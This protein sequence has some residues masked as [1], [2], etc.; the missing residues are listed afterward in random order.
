MQR[1]QF[2]QRGVTINGQPVDPAAST[3]RAMPRTSAAGTDERSNPLVIVGIVFLAFVFLAW[4]EALLSGT[5]L[6]T[7]ISQTLLW[8]L[9]GIGLVVGLT[10]TVLT[11]LTMTDVSLIRRGLTLLVCPLL[12]AFAFGEIAYRI[13]DWAEFGFSSQQF[14]PAQ[15]P[16]ASISHG[17]RGARSTIEIDPFDTGDNTEIPVNYDQ[18]RVLLKTSADSCVTVM[19]RKSASGAIE[20]QTNGRYMLNTPEEVTVVRCG[21]NGA[22]AT[23]VSAGSANPWRKD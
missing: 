10:V 16:I 13:S 21:F 15:Y 19:Q 11:V 6:I 3:P 14:E 7:P 18:Y 1:T 5:A 23:P 12:I 20:I 22:E 4:L 17:R 9:R 8:S 2:G